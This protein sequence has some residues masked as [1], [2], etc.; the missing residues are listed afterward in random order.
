MLFTLSSSCNSIQVARLANFSYKLVICQK[1]MSSVIFSSSQKSFLLTANPRGLIADI[2][3]KN[4]GN[5]YNKGTNLWSSIRL[6]A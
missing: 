5:Q 6:W 1:G 3:C 4:L 2:F